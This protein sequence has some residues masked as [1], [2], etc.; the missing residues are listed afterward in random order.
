MKIENEIL[1]TSY[2]KYTESLK[3][4]TFT[5]TLPSLSWKP[6]NYKGIGKMVKSLFDEG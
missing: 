2:K 1:L 5:S 4:F 3:P 6:T